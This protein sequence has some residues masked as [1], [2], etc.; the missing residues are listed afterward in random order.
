MTALP[1]R[2]TGNDKPWQTRKSGLNNR[3]MID[4]K[5]KL[6]PMQ[7]DRTSDGWKLALWLL[8]WATV[9]LLGDDFA[10]LIAEVLS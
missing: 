4:G 3:E 9:Y 8:F 5:G 6:L 10:K 7:D 2:T 1:I